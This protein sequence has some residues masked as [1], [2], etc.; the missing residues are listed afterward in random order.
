[1]EAAS[2]AGPLSRRLDLERW[3]EPDRRRPKLTD[4]RYL[5]LAALAA[6]ITQAVDQRFAGRTDLRALDVGCGNKPYLPLVA[7]RCASYRGI[8]LVDGPMVDDVGTAEELPYESGSFDLVM[9]TQVFEHV[10]EPEGTLREIHRVL[11]PGG[12]ALVSTHG[13]Y[14]Y[15]PDPPE[16]GQ[17]FWRW[18]HAGLERM[19]RTTAEWSDIEVMPNGHAIVCI[20]T[21]VAWQVHGLAERAGAP[22][23]LSRAALGALNWVARA[24]DARYPESVRTPNPGSLSTNYLV[25]AKK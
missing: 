20:A 19:F 15:H 10:P 21:L 8:D 9:C 5:H 17:D 22:A 6:A 12:V 14:V 4:R 13:V 24:L 3:P 18:T 23:F 7:H 2:Q 1:V 11:A 25:V 16:S